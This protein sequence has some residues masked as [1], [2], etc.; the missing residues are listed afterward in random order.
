MTPL[1]QDTEYFDRSLSFFDMVCGKVGINNTKERTHL[2][3]R[4]KATKS[5]QRRD[6]SSNEPY[7]FTYAD[8]FN[9]LKS[10]SVAKTFCKEHNIKNWTGIVEKFGPKK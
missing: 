7:K 2:K 4:L 6:K 1:T 5:G 9:T 3:K 8:L 10:H